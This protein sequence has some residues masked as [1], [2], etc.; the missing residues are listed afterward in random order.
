MLDNHKP[1]VIIT[2]ANGGIGKAL[3]TEFIDSGYQ[4]IATDIS[5][6]IEV[7]LEQVTF[8]TNRFTAICGR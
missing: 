8:F 7:D 5:N 4:V 3:V 1:W 6:W 2:G